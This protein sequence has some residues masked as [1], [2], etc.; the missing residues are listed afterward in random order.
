M[1]YERV[2]NLIP[3]C[4]FVKVDILAEDD[5]LLKI[6]F[7]CKALE[8]VQG[9]DQGIMLTMVIAYDRVFGENRETSE[10]HAILGSWEVDSNSVYIMD[11]S[12]HA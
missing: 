8:R 3:N 5:T 6:D 1:N 12:R 10:G 9:G 7:K 4:V 11:L 2:I